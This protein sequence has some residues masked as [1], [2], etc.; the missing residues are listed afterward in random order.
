MFLSRVISG[1]LR[2]LRSI[3]NKLLELKQCFLLRAFHDIIK[4]CAKE[5]KDLVGDRGDLLLE[6]MVVVGFVFE[7]LERLR[8]FGCDKIFDA[9][10]FEHIEKSG[11]FYMGGSCFR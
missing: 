8:T 1:L 7:F 6:V 3:K 4:G 5:G 10:A 2:C 11:S 9:I